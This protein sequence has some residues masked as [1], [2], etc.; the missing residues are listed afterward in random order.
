MATPLSI[1][2][3][4]HVRP[5]KN[6]KDAI[7][8]SVAIAQEAERQGFTRVWYAEHHNMATIASSAT[9][10]LIGHVANHTTSIR[11]GSGGVMLPNHAPLV[12]AEQ[13][14]T[15]ASIHGDRIDLGLGRAPGTDQMTMRALRRSNAAA[16]SFPQDVQELASYLGSERADSDINAYPGRGTN[17]PLY[18]LGSSHFGAQLAA[19]LGLPYAFASHFAPTHLETAARLYRENYQPSERHPEPYF[20]AAMNGIAA[21]TTEEAIAEANETFELRVQALIGRNRQFSEADKQLLLASPAAEQVRT[22]LQY[23]AAGTAREVADYIERFAERVQ[24]DE[25]MT[26]LASA[27]GES[28]LHT[29]Q[30]LGAAR[31]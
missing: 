7:D 21:P 25:V 27:S 13:F 29:L 16:D 28:Q 18:I 22:M 14:G 15:L 10:V 1:L 11:L 3:L 30:L 6:I 26:T 8:N 5:G 9:A 12:I 23:T 31:A 24:A 19:Q 2:D 17:V 20:I 4:V